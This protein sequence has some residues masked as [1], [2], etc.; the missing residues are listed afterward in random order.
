MKQCSSILYRWPG[1]ALI[2]ATDSTGRGRQ[3]AGGIVVFKS[4]DQPSFFFNT[5]NNI[6]SLAVKRLNHLYPNKHLLNITNENGFF[7]VELILLA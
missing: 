1:N 7:S 3:G 2:A 6:Y 4:T 5:L